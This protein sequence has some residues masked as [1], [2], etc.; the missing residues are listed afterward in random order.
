MCPLTINR[1]GLL[2]KIL[3]GSRTWTSSQQAWSDIHVTCPPHSGQELGPWSMDFEPQSYRIIQHAHSMVGPTTQLT[4]HQRSWCP[5]WPIRP[6]WA[7][8][9]NH[10]R[11]NQHSGW[12]TLPHQSILQKLSTCARQPFIES[13]S[14]SV[15]NPLWPQYF[16]TWLNHMLGAWLVLL[17]D[18]PLI[19]KLAPH[20]TSQTWSNATCWMP[21]F[22]PT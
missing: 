4:P 12:Q 10:L 21:S 18:Q 9:A 1:I 16:W 15:D 22:D 19:S 17:F 14:W 2:G 8:T 13:N 3:F 11:L 5:S 20:S 6:S 7:P